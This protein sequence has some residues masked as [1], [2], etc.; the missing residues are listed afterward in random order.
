MD[1]PRKRSSAMVAA[2]LP[3]ALRKLLSTSQCW[4]LLGA[5]AT[6]AAFA[7]SARSE[8]ACIVFS[9]SNCAV[10]MD[11]ARGASSWRGQ[12]TTCGSLPS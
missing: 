2:S 10:I 4:S 7:S 8:A 1:K 3:R 9:A 6:L 12:P 5:V 11:E